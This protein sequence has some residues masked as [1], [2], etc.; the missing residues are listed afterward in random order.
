MTN[1]ATAAPI[2]SPDQVLVLGRI[3]EIQ[4]KS[5][6]QYPCSVQTIA[7]AC[8]KEPDNPEL[9]PLERSQT[10]Q[11]ITKLIRAGLL[12][13]DHNHSEFSYRHKMNEALHLGPAQLALMANLMLNGPQTLQELLA[14]S[15]PFYP[16][17][18]YRHIAETLRSLRDE[19][20][21]PLIRPLPQLSRNQKIHYQH[22]FFP[23][24]SLEPE[25]TLDT[26][27]DELTAPDIDTTPPDNRLNELESR[28]AELEAIIE[29]LMGDSPDD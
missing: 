29:R 5:P 10:N 6:D 21:F 15:H 14:T 28:V 1:N 13:V 4:F 22:C 24:V 9:T 8:E 27:A 7:S 18:D 11:A 16:F 25:D 23:E 2:L 12:N 20:P 3:L 17:Q 19:R 26:L